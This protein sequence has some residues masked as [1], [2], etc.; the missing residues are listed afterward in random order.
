MKKVFF[1]ISTTI[2]FVC[3]S[4]ANAETPNVWSYEYGQGGNLFRIYDKKNQSLEI[5]CGELAGGYVELFF[6]AYNNE[7]NWDSPKD[8]YDK[9][10]KKSKILNKRISLKINGKEQSIPRNK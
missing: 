7:V 5:S 9:Y 1:L 4:L 3:M 8:E 6:D 10:L 2:T